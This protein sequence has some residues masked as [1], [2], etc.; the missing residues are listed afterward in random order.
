[1]AETVVGVGGGDVRECQTL[2]HDFLVQAQFSDL[3]QWQ[4][5]PVRGYSVRGAYHILTSQQLDPL[6]AIADLIWHKQVPLNVSILAWRLLRDR[7]PT[8]V[9]LATRASLALYG[10]QLGCGLACHR[11]ILRIYQIIFYNLLIH[12]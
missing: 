5:D 9:N 12:Q 8:K 11:W 1:M 2:L 6:D 3:W 7:L 10:R 4:P